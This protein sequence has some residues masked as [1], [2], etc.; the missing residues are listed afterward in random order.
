MNVAPRTD[1]VQIDYT[2]A[3]ETPFH[4]GTGTRIGL[5]DRTV[6]RDADEYLYVPGSTIKGVVRE[7]CEQ[8]ARF[9][10]D[11]HNKQLIVSPHKELPA[12][13]E[14]GQT[15]ISMITRIFGSRSHQGGLFFDD[16]RQTQESKAEYDG[17]EEEKPQDDSNN[18]AA[19]AHR[20]KQTEQD[21]VKG[22]YKNIQVDVYTQVR[23]DRLTRTP[24]RTEGGGALYTSEFGVCHLTFEGSIS[25]WL[26]C[27]PISILTT[28]AG[29]TPQDL[30]TYSLLLLLAG[31]HLVERLGG[32]KSAG[33]GQCR[34]EITRL[35]LNK[36][37]YAQSQWRSWLE[38]LDEL[39]YYY[40]A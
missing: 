29:T 36:H 20:E 30:P 37:E 28:E 35:L 39:A 5:I 8:L 40:L 31:L 11:A 4:F 19:D 14:L 21:S 24:V 13:R 32:N 33:K 18:E 38:H 1:R 7:H 9:Y 3:F 15:P 17:R 23:L 22:R 16:A 26:T 2:L 34:C 27:T 10:E 6:V 12:L 25:G